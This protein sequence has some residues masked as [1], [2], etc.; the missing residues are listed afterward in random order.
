MGSRDG[1]FHGENIDVLP[2]AT[3]VIDLEGKVIA[4]NRAMEE[5]TGVS[6][7]SMSE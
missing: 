1:T 2:D 7:E 4:R 3:F 6:A 5:L